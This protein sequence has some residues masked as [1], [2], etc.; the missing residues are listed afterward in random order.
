[1]RLFRP[2]DSLIELIELKVLSAYAAPLAAG[3]YGKIGGYSRNIYT[4]HR[5]QKIRLFRSAE[6][7]GGS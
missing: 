6:K 4:A 5:P 7:I 3:G 2:Q 1:M